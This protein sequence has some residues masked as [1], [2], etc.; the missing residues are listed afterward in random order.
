MT[1]LTTTN[2][3]ASLDVNNMDIKE[4]KRLFCPTATDAD[5][6]YFLRLCIEYNLNPLIKEIHCIKYKS[7]NGE[8]RPASVILAKEAFLKR[9]ASNPKYLG[10]EAWTEKE[11]GTG[12]LVGKAL[13]RVKGYP[14][15]IKTTCYFSEFS[16]GRNLWSSKPRVMIA[17]CALVAALREAFPEQFS[18]LYDQAE[19]EQETDSEPKPKP[20]PRK[21]KHSSEVG[22]LKLK[23][24]EDKP[25]IKEIQEKAKAESRLLLEPKPPVLYSDVSESEKNKYNDAVSL[26]QCQTTAARLKEIVP[27]LRDSFTD[28]AVRDNFRAFATDLFVFKG[29]KKG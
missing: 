15:P 17:K 28:E 27:G 20:K 23:P 1:T 12:E 25:K 21:F 18:G 24:L 26:L 6:I 13:V 5:M 4:A 3:I 11:P 2:E 19:F 29:G 7:K 10:H 16:T 8:D 14:E 22:N 9:A